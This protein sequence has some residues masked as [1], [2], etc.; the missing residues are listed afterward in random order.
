ML[1]RVPAFQARTVAEAAKRLEGLQ[2]A[3]T[4]RQLRTLISRRINH[5]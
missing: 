2:N 4:G 3:L 5:S 1:S